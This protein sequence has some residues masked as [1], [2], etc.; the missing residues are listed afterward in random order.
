MA[1]RMPQ[2]LYDRYSVPL[3]ICPICTR[4]WFG[5]NNMIDACSNFRWARVFIMNTRPDGRWTECSGA[6]WK[7]RGGCPSTTASSTSTSSS[8]VR[9]LYRMKHSLFT[10]HTKLNIHYSIF[11]IRC[12]RF[13][14]LYSLFTVS[15]FTVHPLHYSLFTQPRIINHESSTQN[16]EPSLPPPTRT[17]SWWR[18]R[19]RST[20]ARS[21]FDNTLFWVVRFW[22]GRGGQDSGWGAWVGAG[23]YEGALQFGGR[24]ATPVLVCTLNPSTI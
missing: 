12:S 20:G 1:R 18:T 3:S 21:S 10:I 17:C 19:P 4:C 2:Y 23:L 8:T 9:E 24:E 5:M 11:S 22:S 6:C 13:T 14:I 16:P 7:W 15:L